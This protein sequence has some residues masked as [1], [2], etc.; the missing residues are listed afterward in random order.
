MAA[1]YEQRARVRDQRSSTATG[2]DEWDLTQARRL[3]WP[4]LRTG[5]K[6]A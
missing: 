1:M 3:K 2:A 6:R 4:Y 5:L